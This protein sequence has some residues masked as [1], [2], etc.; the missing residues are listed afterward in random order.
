MQLEL[1]RL[2]SMHSDLRNCRINPPPQNVDTEMGA[3]RRRTSM[4]SQQGAQPGRAGVEKVLDRLSKDPDYK[5]QLLN[6]P[7]AA[8]GDLGVI[9]GGTGAEGSLRCSYTCMVAA[10]CSKT[11]SG[12][13]CKCTEC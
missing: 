8:L 13:T 6:D 9:S 3:K 12:T 10:T 4:S 11:C 1:A 2:G 5:Q 7:D